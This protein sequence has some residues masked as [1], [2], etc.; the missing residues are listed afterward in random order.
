MLRRGGAFALILAA[1]WIASH[2]R[3]VTPFLLPTPETVLSAAAAMAIDGTLWSNALV[4]IGRVLFGFGLATLTAI[5][6]AVVFALRPRLHAFIEPPLEFLRQTP[7]LAL[8]P[9]L[10]LWLG[11][12]E[13]QKVGVIVLAC[14]FPIFLGTMGGLAQVDPRLIEVGRVYG[15]G[16]AAIV[17]RII[18]PAA[19]GSIVTGLRL[20]L[21]H[22]WRALVGAE[23]VAASS[24]LGYLIVDAQNLARTD[25]VLVGVL[26]IGI[27][28]LLAEIATRA[29][30]RRLMPWVRQQPELGNA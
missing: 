18:L 2:G 21:G 17:R 6:L 4:S 10:I 15:L 5:P 13:A 28:G 30:I 20:G 22:S 11:I 29:L 3:L 27:L 8:I 16:P 25:I 26:V 14:F 7:P 1:W 9:L 23:L 12:G 24:G 19:A